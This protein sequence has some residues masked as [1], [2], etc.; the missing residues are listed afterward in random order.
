MIS[1]MV[2]FNGILALT[3]I[4]E[5]MFHTYLRARSITP[6]ISDRDFGQYGSKDSDTIVITTAP[7]YQS[8][9]FTGKLIIGKSD[10]ETPEKQKQYLEVGHW[11]NQ[12]FIISLQSLVD[13][14]IK[15][16]KDKPYVNEHF[17]LLRLCRN[18]FAH[19]I[20][21]TSSLDEV[22]R[23]KNYSRI[24]EICESYDEYS[25][26]SQDNRVDISIDTFIIP[27]YRNILDTIVTKPEM[28]NQL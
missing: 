2:N 6:Y 24:V 27:L 7:L 3:N 16:D 4:F 25:A 15:R 21:Y 26:F 11:I 18:L 23:D 12:C 28:I 13:E 22:Q 5:D 8:Y 10:F 19:N 14:F 1:K 20:C 9:G 17:E